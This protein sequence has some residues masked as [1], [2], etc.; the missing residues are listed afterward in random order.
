M[1]KEPKKSINMLAVPDKHLW[2]FIT[3]SGA[4]QLIKKKSKIKS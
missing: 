2:D 1:V 4:E 3:L